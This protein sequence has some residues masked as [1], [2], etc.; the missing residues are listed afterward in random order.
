[1][2]LTSTPRLAVGQGSWELTLPLR[3]F[4]V[5]TFD[6]VVLQEDLSYGQRSHG[7]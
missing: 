6:R 1:M 4:D 7:Q 3:W 5:G 2:T